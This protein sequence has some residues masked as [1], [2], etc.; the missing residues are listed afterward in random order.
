MYP[1]ENYY[2]F[3][4]HV[5][6]RR[7]AGNV[8]LP[9]SRRDQ[10]VL[11]FNYFEFSEFPGG[12]RNPSGHTKYYNQADG[13]SVVKV[14]SF[15]Y[16]VAY[17]GKTVTFN[18]NRLPQEPPKLFPLGEDE[19]FIE[20]TFDESGYQFFLLFNEKGNYP[21]WVLNEEEG[22]P[23]V[24]EPLGED[25]LVRSRSAFAFWVDENHGNRN[26]LVGVWRFHANRNDYFDG[27]FDQLADN[28]AG[29]VGI[30]E[31]IQRAYPGLRGKID[32]YGIYTDRES[33]TR[34][35]LSTYLFYDTY[36]DVRRFMENARAS[37]DPYRYISE[38]WRGRDNSPNATP[39]P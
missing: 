36:A 28:Y 15:T 5:A 16:Q 2:Y 38:A 20:R 14:D 39:T 22:V 8:R 31:Y 10:G 1:T 32:K 27:P 25:L 9:A 30:S 12:G 19:V 4:L 21:F 3:T 23:D 34:V 13:V 24:L 18:L 33:G 6:G 11:S 7:F 26:V 37:D 35:A 29:E 17:R